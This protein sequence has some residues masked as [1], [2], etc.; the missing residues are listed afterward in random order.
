MVSVGRTGVVQIA[1]V[2]LLAVGAGAA[3]AAGSGAAPGDAVRVDEQLSATT[4]LPTATPISTPISAPIATAVPPAVSTVETARPSQAQVRV[5][6]IGDEWTG[7]VAG[8]GGEGA[9]SWVGIVE[10]GLREQGLTTAFTVET[11]PNGGYARG[12]SGGLTY[13][14]LVTDAISPETQT[15]I[16]FG[17]RNDFGF[18]QDAIA[19]GARAT[20]QQIR[21]LLPTVPLIVIGPVGLPTDDAREVANVNEILGIVAAEYE[22]T[23]VDPATQGWFAGQPD[24][25][26]TDGESPSDAGHQFLAE[27]IANYVPV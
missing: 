13:Q 12:G 10:G 27:A 24:L 20:F 23:F 17:S 18:S 16:V 14:D 21:N 22:A 4:T 26:G 19:E 25:I 7:G 15:V 5:G 11:V 6:I 8:I 2:V 3:I 9:S 1:A